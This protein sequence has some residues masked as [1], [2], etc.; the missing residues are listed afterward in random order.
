MT[1][2]THNSN[3]YQGVILTLSNFPVYVLLSV[4]TYPPNIHDCKR[5]TCLLTNCPV[6]FH[7]RNLSSINTVTRQQMR[8]TPGLIEAL[9][10][11]IQKAMDDTRV[12]QKVS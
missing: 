10:G 3:M 2:I 12:E 9:V 7:C 8:D 4:F 1:G 5:Y 11:Y 6:L